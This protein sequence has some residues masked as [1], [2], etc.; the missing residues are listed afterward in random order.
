MGMVIVKEVQLYYEIHGNGDPLILIA[1]LSAHSQHWSNQAPVFSKH[2]KTILL[3][4]RNSGRSDETDQGN[5][6]VMAVPLLNGRM[7]G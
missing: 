2:F 1:G 7:M 5:T 4:N 3:D 6:K